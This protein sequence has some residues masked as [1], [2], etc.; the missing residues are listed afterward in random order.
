MKAQPSISAKIERWVCSGDS[1]N[2]SEKKKI[3]SNNDN[4][5]E[6]LEGLQ[7]ERR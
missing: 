7:L 3:W 2:W 5:L 6:D 4:V 1:E